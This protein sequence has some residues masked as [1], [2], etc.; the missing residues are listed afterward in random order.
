ML[1]AQSGLPFHL[2]DNRAE[3]QLQS[4]VVFI[5]ARFHCGGC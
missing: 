1:K 5:L 4:Q 2:I 3:G